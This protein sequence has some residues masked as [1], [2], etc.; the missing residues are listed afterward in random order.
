MAQVFLS[1]FLRLFLLRS[2]IYCN[3][4]IHLLMVKNK[5]K[6]FF[7]FLNVP[8]IYIRLEKHFTFAMLLFVL[9]F[10]FFLFFFGKLR[11][12]ELKDF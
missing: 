4:F 6:S 7:H 11:Q 10:F 5:E 12:D 2:S 8:T 1:P 9:R 3:Y